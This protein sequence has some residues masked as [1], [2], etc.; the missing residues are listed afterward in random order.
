MD[1]ILFRRIECTADFLD[2]L[3][4]ETAGHPFLTANVLIEFVDWLI[5]KRRPQS[6]LR[7]QRD[8]FT[9]F[10]RKKMDTNRILMSPEYVFFRQAAASALSEQGYRDNP[11]LFAAYWVLRELSSGKSSTFRI[12]RT[13]FRET[14]NRIPI[15]E[16][17]CPIDSSEILR[18]ASQ[19]NFLAYDD[20]HVSVRVRTLGRIAAAVRPALA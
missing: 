2:A 5:E 14:I 12:S 1:K 6:G 13:K 7:V 16:G 11:W 17:S 18:T 19:S 10:A 8:D 15:P 20:R 9:K 4:E 3:Y